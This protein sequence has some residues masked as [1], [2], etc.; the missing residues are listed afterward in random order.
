MAEIVFLCEKCGISIEANDSLCGGTVACPNCQKEVRVPA[1]LLQQELDLN[2]FVL[3]KVLGI[4][5]MGQ[6]WL[7]HQ[8]AM[9]RKIA[10]KILDPGLS[11]NSEFIERFLREAQNLAKLAHDNVVSVIDAGYS[12]GI[13]YMAVNFV[14]GYEL[15][16]KLDEVKVIPEKQALELMLGITEGLCFAWN[17]HRIIHR[18]IKPAN[19]MID[20]EGVPKLMDL[21]ISKC[22]GQDKSLTMTGV[23]VGTPYY[24]SPEQGRGL[25][26]LDF[27]SDIYSLGATLYHVVTGE[28]PYNGPTTISIITQHILEPFPPPRLRNPDVSEQCSV[29]LEIMMAKKPEQRQ[30][31]WEQVIRDMENV[32]EG[33]FPETRC[34]GTGEPEVP[35]TAAPPQKTIDRKISRKTA[36]AAP[37]PARDPV[38][39]SSPARMMLVVVLV[40]LVV[41]LSAGITVF[42]V[43]S[44]KQIEPQKT[45]H[46]QNPMPPDPIVQPAPEKATQKVPVESVLVPAPPSAHVKKADQPMEVEPVRQPEHVKIQEPEKIPEIVNV[47]VDVKPKLPPVVREEMPAVDREDAPQ[48]EGPAVLEQKPEPVNSPIDNLKFALKKANRNFDESAVKMQIGENGVWKIDISNQQISNISPL[49]GLSISLLNLSRTEVFDLNSLKGSKL[50]ELYLDWSN[51]S[52]ISP[53]KGLPLKTLSLAGLQIKD[54]STLKEMP[55]ENLNLSE[56]NVRDIGFLKG[57]QLKVLSLRRTDVNDLGPLKGMKL[58][59]LSLF[60]T[61][62]RSLKPIEDIDLESIVVSSR[63]VNQDMYKMF[64][65]MKTLKFISP[66]P[67]FKMPAEE[68]FKRFAWA[69]KGQQPMGP[70]Q[71]PGPGGIRSGPVK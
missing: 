48:P 53:L 18:D 52:D 28:L 4:G 69:E 43:N 7:A 16:R 8:T 45:A 39:R 15:G 26:E 46:V 29:L 47:P 41:A 60:E 30:Q 31:S 61:N 20:G 66:G 24:I 44:V 34:P 68:F 9:N 21:G 49:T 38:K 64:K 36:I 19:I 42:I 67:D 59:Q 62:Y 54:F 10:L 56:S 33:K 37:P 2:G 22:V 35:K 3:E 65:K 12:R 57:R 13:Y 63:M 23:V 14:D 5:G 25:K 17:K 58:Q 70:D 50:S 27:R 6:V 55:L 11:K 1:P 71:G 40:M 51:V 32:L